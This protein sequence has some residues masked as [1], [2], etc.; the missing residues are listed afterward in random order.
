E[1]ASAPAGRGL[2]RTRR[3]AQPDRRHAGKAQPD[4]PGDHRPSAGAGGLRHPGPQCPWPADGQP[5]RRL[6]A[7]RG[8]SGTAPGLRHRERPADHAFCH[9]LRFAT[10]PG[11]TLRPRALR[12]VPRHQPE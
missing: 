5:F 10:I 8:G 6:P 3:A 4:R 1:R 9:P 11:G 7:R 2:G 12:A